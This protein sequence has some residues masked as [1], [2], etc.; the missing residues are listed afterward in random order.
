MSENIEEKK[1]ESTDVTV[2]EVPVP[3]TE[4]DSSVEE[5]ENTI[6]KATAEESFD[7]KPQLSPDS[8]QVKK[9]T[10]EQKE[11]LLKRAKEANIDVDKLEYEED[12]VTPKVT[13]EML[14]L[15]SIYSNGIFDKEFFQIYI[16]QAKSIIDQYKDFK[17]MV[18]KGLTDE[19]DM[20]YYSG[21][22]KGYEEARLIIG[23]VQTEYTKMCKDFEENKI[24]E[25][26]SKAITLS[27]LRD[28][29]VN[30][31]KLVDTW[32]HPILKD[33]NVIAKEIAEFD[34]TKELEDSIRKMMFVA[35]IFK[36]YAHKMFIRCKGDHSLNSFDKKFTD[37]NFESL[38]Y[39]LNSYIKNSGETHDIDLKTII[40]R[41]MNNM[42][43][44]KAILTT[45]FIYNND[46][47]IKD[48]NVSEESLNTLKKK[49]NPNDIYTKT[50]DNVFTELYKNF[51]TIKQYFT[52][53]Q[54]IT[55]LFA[56]VSNNLTSDKI[57]KT[58]NIDL[59]ESYDKFI[60][61]FSEKLPDITGT[62]IIR[63]G[64]Y[65]SYLKKYEFYHSVKLL[66]E[67]IEGEEKN[68]KTGETLLI[69]CISTY[70]VEYL[71]MIYGKI[72]SDLDIFVK[73]NVYSA[74]MRQTM[75]AMLTNSIL[76]Q[77]ELG[78][79][80]DF[81]PE[82][83]STGDGLYELAQKVFGE[84][85]KFI[86][87]DKEKD[88]LLKDVDLTETRKCYFNTIDELME[89]MLLSCECIMKG[90]YCN[91]YTKPFSNTKTKKTKKKHNRK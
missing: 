63:W 81:N 58:V 52:D 9:V 13:D 84:Q 66:K 2:I 82:T 53:K 30:E 21:L 49:M 33:P 41:D 65:Y 3:E 10:E 50:E 27:L 59:N 80:S 5:V 69:D 7:I 54:F 8:E 6:N 22:A 11:Y 46:E 51:S 73:E 43:F 4:K 47:F 76:M 25:N 34:R 87:V 78:F 85:Y 62:S 32:L 67:Y 83:E 44:V 72:L 38:I 64:Q 14:E 68:E 60:I 48:I 79:K 86:I 29:F 15:F 55:R 36:E 19:D 35:P 23:L 28:Y 40:T 90:D 75:F 71:N 26:Q 24:F 39:G 74:S 70:L 45:M 20:E 88:I 12:G 91:D 18:D 89:F 16:D 1:E 57:F 17:S 77:H 61:K 56:I 37:S 42:N 31:F